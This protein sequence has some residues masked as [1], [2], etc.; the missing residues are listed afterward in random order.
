MLYNSTGVANAAAMPTKA[1]PQVTRG[2][3]VGLD[4]SGHLGYV[5]NWSD[6][7]T[8]SSGFTYG[9]SKAEN[10]DV[11]G[12]ARLFALIPYNGLTWAP[13]ASVTVDQQFGFSNTMNIPSQAALPT[14]DF[15]TLQAAETFWG[16]DIGLDA[17]GP[18]GWVIGVKGFYQESADLTLIGGA[19]YFKI[20]FNY[21][22]VVAARY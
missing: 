21:A 7:F 6:G 12:R 14:G 3:W 9:T 20:P 5:D 2:Y 4:L 1:P 16:G 19:A 10:G 11:G 13:Y 8:D 17:R 22:P 15:V 18:G